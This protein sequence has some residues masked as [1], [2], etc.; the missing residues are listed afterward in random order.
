[1]QNHLRVDIPFEGAIMMPESDRV[2]IR[3]PKDL[4]NSRGFV[5]VSDPSV[6]TAA[7]NQPIQVK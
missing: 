2:Q 5:Y 1:M 7:T 6:K 4:G 3:M